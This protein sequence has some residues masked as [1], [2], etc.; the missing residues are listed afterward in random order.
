MD[1]NMRLKRLPLE[2]SK[3]IVHKIRA[4]FYGNSNKT[5]EINN[6]QSSEPLEF[7]L[8]TEY[9]LSEEE[10]KLLTKTWS[11]GKE[12]S[13]PE[14][15]IHEEF[16]KQVL[17]TPD[18]I[19][20]TYNNEHLTYKE[21][22]DK[23]NQMAF[24][25]QHRGVKAETFV[26]VYLERS[27]NA[28]VS[29]MGILKAG[30]AYIPID[31]SY[32]KERVYQI[33]VDSSPKLVITEKRLEKNIL[34]SNSTKILLDE[35]EKSISNLPTNNLKSNTLQHN[36]AYI[37]Y[38][39]G[40]TGAPKG[41]QIEHKAL[42]N[43]I[44]SIS[45]EYEINNQDNIIQF[46]ALGFD[47][48]VFDIFVSF[49]T[50]ATLIM[51]N[52]FE[53]KSPEQLT[54]LMQEKRVTVAELPPAL[55][56]LLNPED[57]P[58]LRLIS[59]GGEKF[60]GDIINKWSSSKRKFMNG[61]GP[62]ETTVAVTLFNC[63]GHW[64][65]NPPIGKP[66]HNV[67]TYVLNNKLEPVPVG[68]SGELYIGGKCLA[69]GYLNREDL[70]REKFI[71]NPFS[72]NPQSRLYKTGDLVKWLPDGNIE[73]LGRVD[74]QIKIRGFRVELGEVES[75]ILNY[76]NLKQVVVQISEDITPDK[77]LIAYIVEDSIEPINSKELREELSKSLPKYMIPSRFIK[78]PDIP[79]TAHGKID[80]KALPK[81]DNTRPEDEDYVAPRNEIESQ[82][83]DGIFSPILGVRQIG[84]LDNF[85]DLGGN[86]LQATLV[87][88]QIRSMF[89]IDLNLIDFFQS[90][91]VESLAEQV[92]NKTEYTKH[93]KNDLIKELD[94]IEE[95]WIKIHEAPEAKYRIVCFPYAGSS[96][97]IFKKWPEMLAP[98]IEV[99]TIELPGRDAK[100][101]EKP[102][103]SAF[104][105]A[106]RLA[107]EL[108]ALSD[109][110]LIFL[111][112]SG[113]AILAFETSRLLLKRGIKIH[114]LFALASRAPHAELS[115]PARHHLPEVEFLDRVNEFGGLSQE[116][117]NNKDLLNLMIP[118]MRADEKLAETYCYTGKLGIFPFPISIYG[119]K[120]D[121]ISPEV[122]KEWNKLSSIDCDFKMFDGGHFFLQENE[123]EVLYSIIECI[124]QLSSSY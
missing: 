55:L 34:H 97:Y 83:C 16:E 77:Q 106:N 120:K 103:D 42:I 44:V 20:I 88:S 30:G 48:S 27:L 93:K 92:K 36:L 116:F 45:K 114:R 124:A 67:E 115:E 104:I 112:Q 53:R 13:F 5:R 89:G 65:K 40:S 24:Y 9:T 10:Y 109:K 28:I 81:P 21:L 25:L 95:S 49:Y 121:R 56:P 94:E 118:T 85:F 91:I 23:A 51:T 2:K 119:G 60:S 52:E 79:L 41:V 108:E 62:T 113:G 11:K 57:F 78:V 76:P 43:F 31:P 29:I 68:V 59:V 39:S 72:D 54:R 70:T 58:D 35:E 82:I 84:A 105:V 6:E 111:G 15:T 14:H 123:D 3:P 107:S 71:S 100:I 7:D 80:Y 1:L 47:V 63:I 69:R 22:N 86:S 4:G 90:P 19:A 117:L 38:T 101:R 102:F 8:D 99:I 98:D 61:Y 50:G 122:L 73:I 75:A 12:I 26:A 66:I 110:P 17:K 64:E 18:K 46:A 37:I 32:P 33:L 96:T 87:V 74:R